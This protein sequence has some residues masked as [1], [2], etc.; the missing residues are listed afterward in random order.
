MQTKQNISQGFDKVLEGQRKSAK[1]ANMDNQHHFR[2]KC[3][4]QMFNDINDDYT[5]LIN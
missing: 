3:Y 5:I 1:R 4:M 2:N